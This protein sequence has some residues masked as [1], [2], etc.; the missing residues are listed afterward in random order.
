VY[1]THDQVE[2]M[3]MGHRI[4]I[5]ERGV[6]QQVDSPQAVYD[7]PA[8]LFV[9]RF[10]GTPPMNTFPGELVGRP[11]VVAGVRPE[12]LVIG[13][14][15][16]IPATVDFVEHLGHEQLVMC[17]LADGEIIIVRRSSHTLAVQP[18]DAVHL[19]VIGDVY[20]FDAST[21]ERVRS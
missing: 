12:H 6:L 8:N 17:R 5:L 19:A 21:G 4:A 7:E 11:G 16:P 10:I 1:V 13:D 2:A 9:A 14:D 18:L 20:C 3:T 15:G